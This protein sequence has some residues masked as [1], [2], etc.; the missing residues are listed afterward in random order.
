MLEDYFDSFV[1]KNEDEQIEVIKDLLRKEGFTE[2][3]VRKGEVTKTEWYSKNGVENVVAFATNKYG[4]SLPIIM[5]KKFAEQLYAK[6]GEFNR[7][8]CIQSHSTNSLIAK[9]SAVRLHHKLYEY[10]EIDI[11]EGMQ[12]DHISGHQ[13]IILIKE[14]RIVTDKQNKYNKPGRKTGLENAGN[15]EYDENHDFRNS[16]WI[17]FLHYV[18]GA[19][20]REDMAKLRE[21]ELGVA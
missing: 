14:L 11:P 2:K 6:N 12:I 5:P 17:P 21:M 7:T 16:F 18:L 15:C 3:V 4:L 8:I 20:S 9:F 1:G 19:V 10:Y 13:G